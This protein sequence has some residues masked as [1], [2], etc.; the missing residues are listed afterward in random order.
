MTLLNEKITEKINKAFYNVY[1]QLAY[2]FL[3]KVYEN[4]MI[5]ELWAMDLASERQKKIKVTYNNV[6]VGD[7]FAD[8]LVEDLVI[9]E[10]KAAQTIAVNHE[11]QL[12]NYLQAADKEV[13][14]LLNFGKK[15]DFKR[16]IFENRYKAN[17]QNPK[18]N[19]PFYSGNSVQSV[20]NY[21]GVCND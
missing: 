20:D 11:A 19:D 4:A 6:T 15:A 9:V 16:L 18:L 13:G 1:N 2:G 8:I 10:L 14:L 12:L 7:Y 3:E 5:I 17:Q 21:K